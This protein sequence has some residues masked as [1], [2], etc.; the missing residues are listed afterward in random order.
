MKL[1]KSQNSS[2]YNAAKETLAE[3]DLQRPDIHT[4]TQSRITI[5]MKSADHACL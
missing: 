4:P 1:L 3:R 5:K 2:K